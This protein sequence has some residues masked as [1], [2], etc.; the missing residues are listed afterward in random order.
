MTGG[1]KIYIDI[2]D[3]SS[4]PK[5]VT[6]SQKP[7]TDVE[8]QNAV[9]TSIIATSDTG[10][11]AN[12]QT[13]ESNISLSYVGS[14]A[15]NLCGYL[16]VHKSTDLVKS[17]R[18]WFVFVNDNCRLLY[19]RQPKD[20]VPRCSIDIANSSFCFCSIE[21]RNTIDSSKFLIRLVT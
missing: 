6:D 13:E 7:D 4:N 5:D 17:R 8:H 16:K 9:G 1:F 2:F 14:N 19:F 10:T 18:R 11:T 15:K 21:K 3:S 20:I 12:E